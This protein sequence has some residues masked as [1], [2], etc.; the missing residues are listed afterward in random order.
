MISHATSSHSPRTILHVDMDAFYASVEIRDN[1]S[2]SDKPVIVGGSPQSRGVVSAASYLARKFGV[3]S[4]M[5]MSQAIRLCPQA[6]IVRPRIDYYAEVSQQIRAIF[7][8]FTPEIEPLSLDEA[9]LDV[10]ASEKLFGTGEQIAMAIKTAI[11][12][13]LGLVASVGVAPNK[14][15]AKI[16]SDIRKPDALVVVAPNE[17]QPFLDPLPVS[18]LWGAGKATVAQFEKL[19]IR[20][21]AQLRQL[22][23]SLL[24]MHLG[25]WGAHLWQLAHGVDSRPVESDSQAKSISHETT[26]AVD[27]G[28]T[29]VL[30][31]WLLH[32]TEQVAARLRAAE[33]LGKTIQLKLRYPD[34]KTI[35]RAY[36]LEQPTDV[37]D[38][39]WQTTR[40][41]FHANWKGAPPLRLIGIGVSQLSF[42]DIPAPS[43]G[44]LFQRNAPRARALDSIT[45]TINQKYGASTVH[46][47]RFTK[48]H[49]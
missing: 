18:R 48:E 17:V 46:R 49:D 5:P 30:E 11:R 6:V 27:V 38:I 41:L 24:V 37:T 12:D 20:T 39:L 14:F 8:R 29:A 23:E 15:V 31:A 25:K 34:F 47:G 32:L 43:Q 36:S 3:H 42:R 26:F 44:D 40:E 1:P 9:F 19:G 45:D 21:I 35:T 10:S 13:E 22:S 28:D 4:A 2:L 33:L 16:A 7:N